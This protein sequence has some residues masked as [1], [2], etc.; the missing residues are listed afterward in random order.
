[1]LLI[2]IQVEGQE[3]QDEKDPHFLRER[4]K[5]KS[6]DE[7][8]KEFSS[9]PMNNELVANI[10]S[11]GFSGP[12]EEDE[13]DYDEEDGRKDGRAGKLTEW[14]LDGV[15]SI[16]VEVEDELPKTAPKRNIRKS[17]INTLKGEK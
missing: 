16:R 6:L 3:R 4:K 2:K 1:M 11:L 7:V 15:A 8:L 10:E 9:R 14:A 13:E 5:E 12:D 17:R